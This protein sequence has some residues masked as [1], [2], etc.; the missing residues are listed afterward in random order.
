[1]AAIATQGSGKLAAL[2]SAF[3]LIAHAQSATESSTAATTALKACKPTTEGMSRAANV[4]TRSARPL[5]WP[6][7]PVGAAHD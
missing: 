3:I 2:T 7:T 4:A 6:L 1:M 5:Q